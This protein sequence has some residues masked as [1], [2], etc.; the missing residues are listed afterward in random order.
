MTT[1]LIRSEGWQTVITLAL[2]YPNSL[3]KISILSLLSSASSLLLSPLFGLWINKSPRLQTIFSFLILEKFL[4]ITVNALLLL[5]LQGGAVREDL[6]ILLVFLQC[7]L[8]PVN[9]AV[10]ICFEK[11]WVCSLLVSY[12][13]II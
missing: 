8:K 7:I 11:D 9:Q 10:Q 1:F 5:M 2:L 3:S 13:G 4:I 6:F 12:R